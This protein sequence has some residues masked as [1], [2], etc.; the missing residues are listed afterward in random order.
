MEEEKERGFMYFAM[1][2][3]NDVEQA[4]PGVSFREIGDRLLELWRSLSLEE[5]ERYHDKYRASSQRLGERVESPKRSRSPPRRR[6]RRSSMFFDER[7]DA[8][9]IDGE[10]VAEAVRRWLRTTPSLEELRAAA[11]LFV[12]NAEPR[13]IEA[14]ARWLEIDRQLVS[15]L[16]PERALQVLLRSCVRAYES[17]PAPWPVLYGALKRCP[18]A[19]VAA[20]D[21]VLPEYEVGASY[22]RGVG[23]PAS[24]A[25]RKLFCGIAL[26]VQ[27]ERGEIPERFDI[28]FDL[29]APR[30]VA[31]LVFDRL[32]PERR[33]KVLRRHLAAASETN[34]QNVWWR[35]DRALP[36]ADMMDDKGRA[37]LAAL[38]ETLRTRGGPK[39]QDVVRRYERSDDDERSDETVDDADGLT[40]Q[41]RRSLSVFERQAEA[42]DL[43][44]SLGPLAEAKASV[45]VVV[46]QRAPE[47]LDVDEWRRA[48]DERRRQIA[49][50]VAW[51][52]EPTLGLAFKDVV[53]YDAEETLPVAV[54]SHA[55]TGSLLSLVPGGTFL[56][57]FSIC[58]EALVREVSEKK[59]EEGSPLWYQEFGAM[60][61]AAPPTMR[62]VSDVRVPPFL[63]FQLP[64]A[65]RQPDQLT[66]ALERM[67]FRLPSEAEWEYA[68]RAT[69]E[70][71]LTWRGH[72]VPDRAFFLDLK[73]NSPRLPN[74]FGLYCLG[75]LPE[76][77]G[78]V[79]A[80]SYHGAPA[81]GTPR[82]GLGPRVVRG[83]ADAHFPWQTRGEWHLLTNAAR[84]SQ[85]DF[86]F[87]AHSIRPALGVRIVGC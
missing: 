19:A 56:R 60:L 39:R 36:Y 14:C 30:P 49:R 71:H 51:A 80:P 55:P 22:S 62:P 57:G 26:A 37:R 70:S 7:V 77:C 17:P 45:A 28:L 27:A 1:A 2:H 21:E 13:E 4:H 8:R 87:C 73:T 72:E 20:C 23:D 6:A 74:P 46:V 34:V 83:G 68:S 50:A 31:R 78:D 15:R 66:R 38:V 18:A 67:P 10:T 81:D 58:E 59:R 29:Y 25:A 40:A 42:D 79:F 35:V 75:M 12:T 24:R 41:L 44:R 61:E 33:A 64:L 9:S 5:Q 85:L 76:I 3:R 16:S 32:P 82:T 52:A 84:R 63:V 47:L 69:R 53:Y 11:R 54:F 48:P 86:H 65:P 43:A